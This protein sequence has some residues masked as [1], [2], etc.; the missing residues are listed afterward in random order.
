MKKNNKGFTLLEIVIAVALMGLVLVPV[1]QLIWSIFFTTNKESIR[2][3]M[4]QKARTAIEDI[5]HEARTALSMEYVRIYRDTDLTNEIAF[6]QGNVLRIR[7]A[8]NPSNDIWYRLYSSNSRIYLLKYPGLSGAL[9]GSDW[10]NYIVVDKIKDIGSFYIEI[11]DTDGTNDG[12]SYTDD[13]SR[14]RKYK[15]TLN[16]EHGR[17][18]RDKVSTAMSADFIKYDYQDN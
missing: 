4:N 1:T 6:G 3:D 7:D 15:I 14:Y 16:M 18:I 10:R 9:P 12:I 11:S 5:L 13:G 17:N 8:S 2:A